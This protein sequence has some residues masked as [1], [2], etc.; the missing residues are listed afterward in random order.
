MRF[1]LLAIASVGCALNQP[2]VQSVAP[3]PEPAP[4]GE[5]GTLHC[6]QIL[7]DCDRM[8]TTPDCVEACGARGLP[9]A[10]RL[11]GALVAC[12]KASG[13]FEQTC[14]M[15]K[16]G[17]E[18]EACQADEAREEAA[19]A[20][21]AAA[22]AGPGAAPST[23]S[24]PPPP[25]LT[26]KWSQGSVSNTGWDGPTSA[27]KPGAGSGTSMRLEPD[28]TF[29]RASMLET[30]AGS[31]TTSAFSWV[32]GRWAVDGSTLVLRQERARF[33]FADGCNP[34]KNYENSPEPV[35]E[36]RRYALLPDG[37]TGKPTLRLYAA[38]GAGAEAYDTYFK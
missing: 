28:G 21:P 7:T 8:C 12:A 25:G 6:A 38:D 20:P 10:Q 26:G 14:V 36:S 17:A 3:D 31:C 11:H 18:I 32:A 9:D 34:G 23:P 13:C 35:T 33:R 24:T 27:W 37:A 29:E 2:L 16:C 30:T 1:K 5:V 22:D 15:D 19:T 4:S